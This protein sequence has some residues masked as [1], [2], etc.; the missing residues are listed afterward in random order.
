MPDTKFTRFE[1]VSEGPNGTILKRIQLQ[2]IKEA[3]FCNLAF[4]DVDTKTNS[5]DDLAVSNNRDTKKY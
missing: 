2:P 1:F 5:I 3:D 4:G